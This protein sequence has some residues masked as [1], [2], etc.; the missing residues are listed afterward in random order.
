LSF[1]QRAFDST[2]FSVCGRVA[3]GVVVAPGQTI[4]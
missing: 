1:Q 2:M 3:L 4:L